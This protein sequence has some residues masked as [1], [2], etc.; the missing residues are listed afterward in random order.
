MELQDLKSDWQNAGNTFKTDIDILN[1]TRITN[2]PTLKKIRKKLIAEI[3]CLM[4]FLVIYYDW[5]DGSKKP[6]YANILLAT[7]IILYIANDIIGY[8]SIANPI[9]GLSLK[10]S[11]KNYLARL[12]HLSLFSLIFSF[13][14]SVCVIVFFTSAIT[15]TPEKSFLVLGLIIILF[16]L[17]FWSYRIWTARIKWLVQQVKDFDTDEDK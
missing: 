4:F 1:M 2:H 6:L 3:I 14:Y 5:F 7:G 12:K 10:V 16:Q 13:V 17:M 9:N 11:F 15:L 8:V